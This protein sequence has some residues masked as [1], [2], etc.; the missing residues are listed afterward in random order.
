MNDEQMLLFETGKGLCLFA[1]C[2]HP[3]I[4]NCLEYVSQAFPGQKLHSVFAGMH[5]TGA[6]AQRITETAG[7]LENVNLIFSCRSTVQALKPSAE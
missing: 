6:S 4:L 7:E 5:L 1:G 2:C 3:G